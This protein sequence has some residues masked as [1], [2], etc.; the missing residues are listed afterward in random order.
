M[1]RDPAFQFHLSIE[2]DLEPGVAFEH[3][4]R[5][6]S[7]AGARGES[8]GEG[9]YSTTNPGYWFTQLAR[10]NVGELPRH[11]YLVRIADPGLGNVWVPHQDLSQ[12]GDIVVL[13]KLMV[14]PDDD[15]PLDVGRLDW[16]ADR[17]LAANPDVVH[18]VKAASNYDRPMFF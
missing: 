4:T 15:T 16:F 2:P 13:A 3:Q 10:E 14:V 1:A 12:P 11:V 7:S 6:C 8:C 5:T 18:E 9:I 17:W